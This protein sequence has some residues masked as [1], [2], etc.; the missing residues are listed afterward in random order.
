MGLFWDKYEVRRIEY[1]K[2]Q[3]AGAEC[4]QQQPIGEVSAKV[5]RKI[6]RDQLYGGLWQHLAI[7]LAVI[8]SVQMSTTT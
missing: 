8:E 1:N 3:Q 4:N 6:I 2:P 5:C 7:K